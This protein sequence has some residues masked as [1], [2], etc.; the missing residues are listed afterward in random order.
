MLK[1]LTPR[2]Q[3]DLLVAD[4]EPELRKAFVEAV[5]DLRSNIDFT[6]AIERLER[7]DVAGALAALHLT[8]AAFRPLER[9]IANAFE[10]GGIA[11]VAAMPKLRDPSGG[12]MVLRFDVRNVSAENWLRTH[13]SKFAEDIT[14]DMQRSIAEALE[15]GL[16]QGLNPKQSI[17]RIAGPLNRVTGKREGGIVGLSH[18][19]AEYV[20]AARKELLS[21]DPALLKNYMTRIRRDKRFDRTI[22]KAIREGK[23]ISAEI[24]GKA[25]TSYSNKLLALR[26]ETI[27]RTETAGALGQA[28][29]EAYAQAIETG[30]VRDDQIEKVWHT[31]NDGKVRDTHSAMDGQRVPRSGRF[32]SPSGATLDYPCDPSAPV[33]EIANCRCWC[34]YR[35]NYLKGVE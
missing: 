26:A 8:T 14:K 27:A 25:A 20:S 18:N 32:V 30:A 24:A 7:K 17:T 10:G 4:F 19:Q 2:E 22:S 35:V 21:G 29:K 23:P 1:R 31:A 12:K 16:S 11:T 13:S 33:E 34:Q 9:A 6:L 15:E 3:F 5:A 28:Q